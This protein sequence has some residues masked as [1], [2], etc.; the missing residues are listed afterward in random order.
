MVCPVIF[1]RSR[2]DANPG[3]WQELSI[4][5]EK[6]ARLV[7]PHARKECA[8]R[9]LDIDSFVPMSKEEMKAHLD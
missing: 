6:N 8:A 5:P 1:P 4:A 9:G 2:V 7:P 3:V